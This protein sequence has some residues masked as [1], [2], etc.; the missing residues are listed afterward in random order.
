LGRVETQQFIA[1]SG[2]RFHEADAFVEAAR[3]ELRVERR[4]AIG[5]EGMSV[6]KSVAR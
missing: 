5:T 2:A 3:G 6:R 1:R 4:V